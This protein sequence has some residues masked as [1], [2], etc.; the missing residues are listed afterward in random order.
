MATRN[1]ADVSQV[2]FRGCDWYEPYYGKTVQSVGGVPS[3][4]LTSDVIYGHDTW[5]G[6]AVVVVN[7]IQVTYP[8]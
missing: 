3:K 4:G 6:S 2:N 8:T 7:P 5:N 1:P